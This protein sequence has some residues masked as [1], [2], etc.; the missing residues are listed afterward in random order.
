MET[1]SLR[2]SAAEASALSA[3]MERRGCTKAEAARQAILAAASGKSALEVEAKIDAISAC[4]ADLIRIV[5][6]Q[7]EIASN[8]ENRIMR[9]AAQAAIFGGYLAAEAGVKD[10]AMAS[11]SGWEKKE[12]GRIK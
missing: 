7:F 8:A 5:S 1:F 6:A 4:L 11:F 10:A 9:Y 2:I 12:E 3:V